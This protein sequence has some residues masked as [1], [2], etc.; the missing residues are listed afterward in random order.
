MFEV[1]ILYYINHQE[2][3]VFHDIILFDTNCLQT[4]E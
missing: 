4:V 1:R 3:T 2:L